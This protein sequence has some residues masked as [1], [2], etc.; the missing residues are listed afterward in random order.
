MRWFG[1]SSLAW[2]GHEHCTCF[3]LSSWKDFLLSKWK[4]L[5]IMVLFKTWSKKSLSSAAPNWHEHKLF[6]RWRQG[7]TL[8]RFPCPTPH[9]IWETKAVKQEEVLQQSQPEN[10][11]IHRQTTA[12]MWVIYIKQLGHYHTVLVS[13]P[14]SVTRTPSQCV[15]TQMPLRTLHQHYGKDSHCFLSNTKMSIA[16]P[17]E[18]P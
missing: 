11:E 4:Y 12:M 6:S 13:A 3:L 17:L 16:F 1:I 8:Q 7:V 10:S 9:G 14:F 18:A 5:L 2:T 15:S